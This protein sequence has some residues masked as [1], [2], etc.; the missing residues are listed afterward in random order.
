[1]GNVSRHN[2]PIP[3]LQ[4]LAY[5]FG[6]V[7][8]LVLLFSGLYPPLSVSRDAAIQAFLFYFVVGLMSYPLR[9]SMAKGMEC[10]PNSLVWAILQSGMVI[11]FIYGICFHDVK[12]GSLRLV[13]MVLLLL[14]LPLM[15]VNI[16]EREKKVNGKSWVFF[17]I[18]AFLLC[19]I[20]QTLL[21]EPSYSEEIRTGIPVIHRCL[22]IY[23]GNLVIASVMLFSP[24]QAAIRKNL[25]T[26]LK[27]RYLWVY[28][29]VL[30]TFTMAS[31]LLLS[32]NAMDRMAKLGMGAISYPIMV[33]SCILGFTLYSLIWL[34]ERLTWEAIA[35]ICLCV[36]GIVF[37]CIE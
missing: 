35:G 22:I 28:S 17:A 30:Q 32:F 9:L 3:L 33:I 6:L 7:V 36:T 15:S 26:Y 20:Q 19:G 24:N 1:M 27:N 31:G 4:L 11:P 2:V 13:G 16:K 25:H 8:G 12:A 37:L 10:G 29:F 18:V 23:I 21:N 14:A 34:R 5:L